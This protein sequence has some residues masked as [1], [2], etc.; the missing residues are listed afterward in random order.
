MT[1]NN[2]YVVCWFCELELNFY[3]ASESINSMTLLESVKLQWPKHK[4]LLLSFMGTKPGISIWH[5]TL[6]CVR[7]IIWIAFAR[8]WNT[9]GLCCAT[10]F[11]SC[12]LKILCALKR[13]MRFLWQQFH[14]TWAVHM[15]SE[16]WMLFLSFDQKKKQQDVADCAWWIAFEFCSLFVLG[17]GSLAS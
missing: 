11:V 7:I 5:L 16:L 1:I 14:S 12:S 4:Q 3:V 15:E 8:W 2:F 9:K 17:R 6:N 13:I 10:A